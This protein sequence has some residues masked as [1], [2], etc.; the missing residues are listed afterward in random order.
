VRRGSSPA[1]SAE[2]GVARPVGVPPLP[3]CGRSVEVRRSTEV[4]AW[5]PPV[6]LA[7]SAGSDRGA[8]EG[9]AKE[10]ADDADVEGTC[11]QRHQADSRQ[12]VARDPT[13]REEAGRDEGRARDDARHTP[14]P[15][16]QELAQPARCEPVVLLLLRPDRHRVIPFGVVGPTGGP[17]YPCMT[18]RCLGG[19]HRRDPTMM[20]M[21]ICQ[22]HRRDAAMRW[23]ARRRTARPSPKPAPGTLEGQP[24]QRCSRKGTVS[25]LSHPPCVMR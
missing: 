3:A 4:R 2:K 1:S 6:T 17:C 8:L 23:G 9:S 5:A 19:I 15:R 13:H 12:D 20:S 7:P 22:S 21:T 24:A 25:S 18:T 11:Q 14:C 10:S 16:G